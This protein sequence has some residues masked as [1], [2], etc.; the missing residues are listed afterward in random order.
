MQRSSAF[1][2]VLLNRAFRS[3]RAAL[4]LMIAASGSF[5][6]LQ[7]ALGL[8]PWNMLNEGLS[9]SLPLT[10]GQASIAISVMVICV[11]L[12]MR[13]SIGLGTVLD[14][15][16]VGWTFDFLLWLEPIPKQT[17]LPFQL[18]FM[19]LGCVI[20]QFG[21]FI[22][23]SAGLSCGP[24][25]AF[26]VGIGKRFPKVPIGRVNMAITVIVLFGG[27]ML[28]SKLGFGTFF[29]I[30][31]GSIIMDLV[32]GLLHFEPRSVKHENLVQTAAALSEAWQADRAAKR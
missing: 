6:Q 17:S 26:L 27:M 23:M 25:D 10:F 24:R 22:Y 21:N 15:L 11:D 31:G 8:N 29:N 20:L 28:G 18:F 14:A 13:E 7:A 2:G 3:V 19:L 4:G 5:L 9:L 12:L 32:F 30:F 1:C 16:V